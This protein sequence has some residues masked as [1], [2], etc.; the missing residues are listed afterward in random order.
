MTIVIREDTADLNV[1]SDGNRPNCKVNFANGRAFFFLREGTDRQAISII[2]T[3]QATKAPID[4][5]GRWDFGFIQLINEAVCSYYFAGSDPTK[6]SVIL[7]FATNPS[8][9]LLDCL[10]GSAPFQNRAP[11]TELTA[12]YPGAPMRAV[13][14]ASADDNPYNIM[15]LTWLNFA[16]NTDNFLIR[17]QRTT[18]LYTALVA[19]DKSVPGPFRILAYVTWHAAWDFNF[20]RHLNTN[21]APVVSTLKAT[22]TADPPVRGAPVDKDVARQIANASS[23][24]KTYNDKAR[25]ELHS[26]VYATANT[27]LIK[28]FTHWDA[29]VNAAPRFIPQ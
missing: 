18:N 14:R 6:G 29:R 1:T 10:E 2:G 17:A 13:F 22:F 26:V 15:E 21:Q 25:G 11:P 27:N 7:D 16:T 28:A 9:Y 20:T 24:D 12:Q 23:S 8:D 5:I 3:V 4:T 19:R